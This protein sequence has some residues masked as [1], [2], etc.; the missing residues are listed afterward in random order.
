MNPMLPPSP[1]AFVISRTFDAPRE[2]VWRVYTEREHLMHW[3]GPKGFTMPH[4]TLDLRPGGVFHYCLEG[5]GGMSMWG[6]WTFREIV[7]PERLVFVVAF[8]DAAGGVTVHPMNPDWPPLTLNTTTFEES[9]GRTTVTLYWQPLDATEV[10]ARTFAQNHAGMRMGCS[11][12]F[13]QLEAYLAR[14]RN[15]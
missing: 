7:R 13:D 5:P 10:Q 3:F 6:T 12:T 8:S 15:G 2:L 9:D 4:A 14:L 1:D 11:G